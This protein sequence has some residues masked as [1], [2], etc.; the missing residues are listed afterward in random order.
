MNE[1]SFELRC[2]THTGVKYQEIQNVLGLKWDTEADELYCVGPQVD[3]EAS[4]VVT[5][6]KLLSIV[7]SIHNLIGFTSPATLLPKLLFQEAWRN[8]L[9]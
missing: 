5:K 9:G 2:W 4:E 6:R 1:A 3:M 7:N 8:K